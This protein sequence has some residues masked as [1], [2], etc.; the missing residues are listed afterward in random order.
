MIFNKK[1]NHRNENVM[2]VHGAQK[3]S[4]MYCSKMIENK[5][6]ANYTGVHPQ[7]V[8]L[9][10]IRI[11]SQRPHVFVGQTF[12]KNLLKNSASAKSYFARLFVASATHCLFFV[13]EI[14]YNYKCINLL[15]EIQV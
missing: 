1:I 8:L 14:M 11:G 6:F 10:K 7:T 3:Q 2:Y 12:R 4:D 5:Q 13:C 9:E 15:T